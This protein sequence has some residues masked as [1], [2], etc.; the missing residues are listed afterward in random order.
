MARQT[1]YL[2]SFAYICDNGETQAAT[3]PQ[4]MKDRDVKFALAWVD[5][6]KY[7]EWIAQMGMIRRRGDHIV[8]RIMSDSSDRGVVGRFIKIMK[9]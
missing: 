6:F 8:L 1:N 3:Q 9:P 2:V 4:L 5:P 7:D